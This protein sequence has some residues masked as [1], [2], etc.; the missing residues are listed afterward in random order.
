MGRIRPSPLGD[1]L[2]QLRVDEGLTLRAAAYA[3][4]IGDNRICDWENGVA[5]PKLSTL[6]RYSP[7]FG[8]TVAQ[9]LHGVM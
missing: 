9:L 3:V 8:L 6:A 5:E 2:R 4:G 7:L 1:R